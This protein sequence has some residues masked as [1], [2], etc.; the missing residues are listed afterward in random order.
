MVALLIVAFFYGEHSAL[1]GLANEQKT[2]PA[3]HSR[4]DD[5]AAMV[6]VAKTTAERVAAVLKPREAM[7]SNGGDADA[8]LH[9]RAEVTAEIATPTKLAIKPAE[10]EESAGGK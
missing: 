6:G 3:F 2:H 8:T 10:V 7:A 9:A 5:V 4:Y 1:H